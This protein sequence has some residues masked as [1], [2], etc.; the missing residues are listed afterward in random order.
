MPIR[1][2][3]LAEA[4]A[5]EELRRKDPV[6][7]AMWIAGFAVFLTLLWSGT[8]QLKISAVRSDISGLQANWR[9]IE[10]Q[11]NEINQQRKQ[12][13]ELAQKIA[14]LD[15]FATNRMLWASALNA[16]QHTMVDGVEL[17]RLRTEQ[18]FT[19]NETEKP[20]TDGTAAVPSKP[21]TVTE[22]TALMVEGKDFSA[23]GGQQVPQYKQALTAF[24]YF[25][26]N[27]SKTNAAQLTS[28]SAPQTDRGRSFVQF[29]LQLFFQEKERQLYE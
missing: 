17:V 13:Q 23:Q 1:I 9:D 20:R 21:A 22:R 16:L 26:A 2:N 29:G 15:Q 8:L 19:L 6:K 24:P 11:V 12:A 7:R 4:Q 27:L 3:L 10:S 25:E 18:V 14:A 28:L 5:A